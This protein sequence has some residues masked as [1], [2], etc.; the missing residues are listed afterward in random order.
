MRGERHIFHAGWSAGLRI[1]HQYTGVI[2]VLGEVNLYGRTAVP[3]LPWSR[4]PLR[5]MQVPERYIVG[6]CWEGLGAT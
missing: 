2:H 5:P 3:Y 4:H 6:I 1:D